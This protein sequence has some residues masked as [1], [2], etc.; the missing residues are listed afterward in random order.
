MKKD[1][2]ITIKSRIG[3]HKPVAMDFSYSDGCSII[4][5]A[6]KS[7]IKMHDKVIRALANR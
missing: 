3:T 4:I 2:G 5:D 6:A 1:Y 7:V